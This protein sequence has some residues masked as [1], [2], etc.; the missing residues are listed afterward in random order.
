M[1]TLLLLSLVNNEKIHKVFLA[2]SMT[3][4]MHQCNAAHITQYS[5]TG[6]SRGATGHP[7]WEI[8]CTVSPRRV[9]H[10]HQWQQH[11]KHTQK[12]NLLYG[13]SQHTQS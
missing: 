1:V 9:R 13:T 5:T 6:A 2:I 12:K 11:T 10:G 8:T 7:H 4:R 3:M